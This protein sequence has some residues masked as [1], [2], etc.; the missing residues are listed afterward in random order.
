MDSELTE[1]RRIHD[2]VLRYCRGIDRRDLEAVR[3]CYHPE[4]TDEHTGFRGTRDEFVD[5]VGGVIG[6][7]DGTMHMVG[8]HLSCLEGERASAETYGLAFHWGTPASD[9]QLNF[10]SAFRYLDRL[11]RREGEWRI[12]ERVAVR[13]WARTLAA[14]GWLAKESVGH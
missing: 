3:D 5:W 10:V 7:F 8:N 4:G 11:E 6:R 9:P 12:L 14:E 13:E 2:L 1:R